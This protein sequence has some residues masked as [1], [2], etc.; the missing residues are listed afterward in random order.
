MAPTAP[1]GAPSGQGPVP[2]PPP[3]IKKRKKRVL[4]LAA[5]FVLLLGAALGGGA[6]QGWL[7]VPGLTSG[8]EPPRP[9]PDEVGPMM[10]VGPLLINLREGSGRHYLKATLV[11]E[12]GEAT[13]AEE[14]TGR[15]GPIIDLAILALCEE[16]YEGLKGL[17]RRDELK[18]QILEKANR[19]LGGRKIKQV[20]WDDFLFQ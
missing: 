17:N 14:V 3:K 2:V 4:A 15:L 19:T 20:Y 12:M 10:R 8:K 5:V 6:L 1:G 9:R 13:S 11:L 18:R 7:E 16:T